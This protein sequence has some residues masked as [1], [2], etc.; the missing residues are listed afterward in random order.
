MSRAIRRRPD[1]EAGGADTRGGAPNQPAS[2]LETQMPLWARPGY[3][4][5]RLHQ[6]QY[7]LFLEECAGYEITPVQYGLLT[8]LAT[9]PD[10]DQNTLGRELGIDRTNVADVLKRLEGRGLIERR[11]S[12]QDRRMMLARLTPAGEEMTRAMYGPMQRAQLRFL[13]PLPPDERSKLIAML[14]RLVDAN[15]HLGRTIFQPS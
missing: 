10:I 9:N 2:L 4:I 11:R 12:T 7:A 5:R 13:D 1:S 8:A 6:I 3:L 15:N 14:M